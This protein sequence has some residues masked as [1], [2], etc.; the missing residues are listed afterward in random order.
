MWVAMVCLGIIICLDY[1]AKMS[2]CEVGQKES[3]ILKDCSYGSMTYRVKW[4]VFTWV[5][6][7]VGHCFSSVG[8]NSNIK[9][10][11]CR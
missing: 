2:Q 1:L 3:Y 6:W 10:L 11:L 4:E 9:D 5:D 7:L 8:R